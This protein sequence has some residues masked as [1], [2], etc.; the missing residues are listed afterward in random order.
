MRSRFP[1]ARLALA[2]GGGL[3]RLALP[4]LWRAWRPVWRVTLPT[5]LAWTP[6]WLASPPAWLAAEQDRLVLWLPVLMGAG[7]VTY[8]ALRQEPPLWAGLALLLP[9]LIG[10]YLA[11]PASVLRALLAMLAAFSLGLAAAQFTTWRAPPLVVLPT[12]AVTITGI[13]RGVDPLPDGRRLLLD[14]K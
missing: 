11:R 8:F 5:W 14:R 2:R 3:A 4:S 6:T 13:V 12:N 7:V 9:A 1:L 10:A